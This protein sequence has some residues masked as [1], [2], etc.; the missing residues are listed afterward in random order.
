MVFVQ[1]LARIPLAATK[2]GTFDHIWALQEVLGFTGTIGKDIAS[3]V[4]VFGK[5]CNLKY[6]SGMWGIVQMH[7][8]SIP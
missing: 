2:H 6:G 4:V 8:P 7:T 3:N 5:N 1:S